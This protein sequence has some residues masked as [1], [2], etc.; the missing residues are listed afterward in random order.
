MFLKPS[1]FTGQ[2]PVNLIS[3]KKWPSSCFFF[4]FSLVAPGTMFWD[5]LL[6]NANFSYCSP[7]IWAVSSHVYSA[8]LRGT[9][10]KSANLLFLFT[11]YSKSRRCCFSFGP[12]FQS[13]CFPSQQSGRYLPPCSARQR[14]AAWSVAPLHQLLPQECGGRSPAPRWLLPVTS[15][16]RLPSESWRGAR[17]PRSSPPHLQHLWPLLSWGAEGSAHFT[18]TTSFS[19][20]NSK[21]Q[22]IWKH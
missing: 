12:V 5:V 1:P 9:F 2:L 10:K 15:G 14:C 7:K 11:F 20:D 19:P 17:T 22:N 6:L 21:A 16:S 13:G 3:F 4:Y 18:H 8:P